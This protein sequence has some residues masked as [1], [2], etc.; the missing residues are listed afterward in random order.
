MT[1]QE[2]QDFSQ[3]QGHQFEYSTAKMLKQ[4]GFSNVKVTPDTR[5]YGIDV[6]GKLNYG[7]SFGV[8]CK[9]LLNPKAHTIGY[10]A[11]EQAISGMKFHHLNFC[12]VFTNGTFSTSA[13]KGAKRNHVILWNRNTQYLLQNLIHAHLNIYSL[14]D[15]ETDILPFIKK[16]RKN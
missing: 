15:Y 13:R 10:S 9:Y 14:M 16:L 1:P 11:V 6:I 5:D 8:Q 4:L 2:Y 12:I 7:R 3:I